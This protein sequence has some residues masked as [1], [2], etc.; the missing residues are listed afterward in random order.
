MKKKI[1]VAVSAMR[2]KAPASMTRC[3]FN[4]THFLIISIVPNF[5][6]A[7]PILSRLSV[8]V[9]QELVNRK[10]NQLSL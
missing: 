2:A 6:Y 4:D 1:S 3:V 10:R 7:L 9:D 5:S 8:L